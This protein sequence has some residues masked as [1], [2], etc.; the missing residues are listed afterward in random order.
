MFARPTGAVTQVDSCDLHMPMRTAK[1]RRKTAD[2]TGTMLPRISR[3]LSLFVAAS[4]L[5]AGGALASTTGTGVW[6]QNG[7]SNPQYSF[8]DGS[9]AAHQLRAG[10][11]PTCQRRVSGKL[12]RQM[13]MSFSTSR[14]RAS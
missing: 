2:P 1:G 4:L 13:P 8:W 9:A 6:R 7:T 5:L 3:R 12:L 10:A 11:P 14:G